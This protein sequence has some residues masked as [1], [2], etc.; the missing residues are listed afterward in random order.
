MHVDG[1]VSAVAAAA[2]AAA[3]ALDSFAGTKS[4]GGGGA[5]QRQQLRQGGAGQQPEGP[6]EGS[7]AGRDPGLAQLGRRQNVVS[8][9]AGENGDEQSDANQSQRQGDY[10]YDAYAD[11]S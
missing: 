5:E 8:Q 6:A 7:G 11:G 3:K 10:V 2:E 1:G 9:P 4:G